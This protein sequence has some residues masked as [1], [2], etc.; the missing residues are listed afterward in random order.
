MFQ[1]G[2]MRRSFR[3]AQ[4]V[5]DNLY[6]YLQLIEEML[7]FEEIN[8]EELL[9]NRAHYEHGS[10]PNYNS[11][12]LKK[13]NQKA[14]SFIVFEQMIA[15]ELSLNNPI[16]TEFAREILFD[17]HQGSFFGHPL[18]RAIFKS[19]NGDMHDALGKLLLAAS[20]QEGL[21]Q[22]IVENIDHGSLDAQLTIMKLIKEH[23]LTRFSSVIRA[24]DTWMG[25]G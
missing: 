23:K 16:I 2:P 20:R 18:I 21:R 11:F 24:I 14:M 9:L 12:V 4:P 3:S 1:T 25:L 5:Q 17:D 10:Y 13:D 15:H 7:T 8:L 19:T 6:Q 22:A